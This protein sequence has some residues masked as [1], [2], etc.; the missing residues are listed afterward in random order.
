MGREGCG[1]LQGVEVTLPSF[2]LESFPPTHISHTTLGR[3]TEKKSTE[4]ERKKDPE[5]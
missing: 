1:N 2:L 4:K 3:Q 5:T